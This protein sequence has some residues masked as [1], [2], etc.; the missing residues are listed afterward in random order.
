M[1]RW[2]LRD[3]LVSSTYQALTSLSDWIPLAVRSEIPFFL[4]CLY[5]SGAVGSLTTEGYLKRGNIG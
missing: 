4:F 3:L 2:S 1:H 5:A